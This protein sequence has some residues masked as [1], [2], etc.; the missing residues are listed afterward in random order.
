MEGVIGFVASLVISNGQL[1][2]VT[3][4]SSEDHYIINTCSS[5]LSFNALFNFLIKHAF[6]NEKKE[7]ENYTSKSYSKKENIPCFSDLPVFPR[8]LEVSQSFLYGSCTKG[9]VAIPAHF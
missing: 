1:K 5:A 9:S 8:S 3:T 7:Q 4:S 2:M 6:Y